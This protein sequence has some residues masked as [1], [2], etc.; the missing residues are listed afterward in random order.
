[1]ILYLLI[2]LVILYLLGVMPRIF[3]PKDLTGFKGRYYAHRGLHKDTN[4]IPENSISAF[5]LAIENQYGIELDVRLTKDNIPVVFHD[6]TLL[7]V[8]GVDKCVR[9]LTFDELSNLYLYDSK[10]RIP[11]FT[12]VLDLVDGQV[13]LIIELKTNENDI[14]VC[15]VVAPIL[16]NYSGV[17]CVESFNPLIL[18]WYK[19][20]RPM[21][22]RGQLSTNY[23][24]DGITNERLL[25]FLLQNLLFNFATKPDFIAFNYK[26][27]NMPSYVLCRN[28]YKT[29]TFA[30]TI[31]SKK[32][33]E[34]S[35][36]SFDLFIFE[37]F[38]P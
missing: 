6:T 14:A 37:R 15:K 38:E 10:E 24:K 33:L 30:Y 31:G 29:P 32:A 36:D 23:I 17:Y 25:N 28:I 22:I 12:E 18:I 7:R 8:C 3:F 20:N 16:D 35:K 13:P 19:K 2:S 4:I 1:M 27:R 26:Y 5:K 34:E 11:L 9:D 21:V